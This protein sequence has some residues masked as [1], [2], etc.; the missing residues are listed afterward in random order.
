MSL[1][2]LARPNASWEAVLVSSSPCA[3][4]LK[5]IASPETQ[6]ALW[7]RERPAALAWL[8]SI[9]HADLADL[10]FPTTLDALDD[11]V[12]EGLA[13][14]GYP[15][16]ER[17]ED[18]HAE[19]CTLARRF[20]AIMD[21]PAVRIRLEIVTTD[22]CR[23]FHADYVSARLISTLSGTGT[24]WTLAENPET[25]RTM[26]RGHV[27]IFKGRLLAPEPLV[28]HRSPP[29]SVLGGTRIVLVLDPL[30]DAKNPA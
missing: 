13:Q 8:D 23:K 5:G 2:E 21:S 6:L 10:A 11:E 1:R 22:A 29:L 15:E 14:A 27:G 19:I 18:L 30:A 28:L 7:L 4:V 9:Q 3:E 26:A 20:A 24:Q 12:R 16:D 25:I 17:G